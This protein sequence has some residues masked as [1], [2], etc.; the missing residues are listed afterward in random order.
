MI[1]I[2]FNILFYALNARKTNSLCYTNG[3]IVV[4]TGYIIP[5][6]LL[7]HQRLEEFDANPCN[8][9]QRRMIETIN[10][11]Y[12]TNELYSRGD[13]GKYAICYCIVYD[14]SA[15]LL[16]GCICS[17]KIKPFTNRVL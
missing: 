5:T 8:L 3:K 2:Y 12:S 17:V 14:F 6:H 15:I 16:V 1:V 10:G 11:E 4:T 7:L 9:S 13:G